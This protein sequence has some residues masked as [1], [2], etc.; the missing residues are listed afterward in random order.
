MYQYPLVIPGFIQM[1]FLLRVYS[2][3]QIIVKEYFVP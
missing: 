1:E 3:M 2:C